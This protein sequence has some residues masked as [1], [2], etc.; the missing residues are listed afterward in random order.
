MITYAYWFQIG[1]EKDFYEKFN[2]WT[3]YYR[4][5]MIRNEKINIFETIYAYSYD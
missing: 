5:V 2:F 1:F 4:I 3:T